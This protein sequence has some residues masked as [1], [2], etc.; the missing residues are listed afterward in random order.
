M[1]KSFTPNDLVSYLYQEL[2][3]AEFEKMTQA[4]HSNDDLMQE[5]IDLRNAFDQLEQIFIQPSDK[6]VDAIKQTVRTTGLEK[7]M[8]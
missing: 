7:A 6:V 8:K 1:T 2:S 5:Y 3:D 4:L